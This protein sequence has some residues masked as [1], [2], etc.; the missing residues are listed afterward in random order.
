MSE[1]STGIFSSLFNFR[2]WNINNPKTNDNLKT[3]E[4]IVVEEKTANLETTNLE[5]VNLEAEHLKGAFL[6]LT[7]DYSDVEEFLLNGSDEGIDESL[8]EDRA[9][10][11]FYQD[12]LEFRTKLVKSI[13]ERYTETNSRFNILVD[14][15]SELVNDIESTML[16][17]KQRENRLLTPMEIKL[18]ALDQI[19]KRYGIPTNWTIGNLEEKASKDFRYRIALT[20]YNRIYYQL[21]EEQKKERH[22]ETDVSRFK[23][24][25]ISKVFRIQK[26]HILE[27]ITALE[28]SHS[29]HIRL[30]QRGTTE[31]L[32]LSEFAQ[33][34]ITLNS[35]I[36]RME[37][38]SHLQVSRTDDKYENSAFL[39]YGR[40]LQFK[41]FPEAKDFYQAPYY[42]P[43]HSSYSVNVTTVSGNQF[44]LSAKDLSRIVNAA[45]PRNTND[46]YTNEPFEKRFYIEA[47]KRNQ[48][49]SSII[50]FI[51]DTR[52]DSLLDL[53]DRALARKQ[54]FNTPSQTISRSVSDLIRYEMLDLSDTS[55]SKLKGTLWSGYRIHPNYWHLRDTVARKMSS[56]SF[57]NIVARPQIASKEAMQKHVKALSPDF[58]RLRNSTQEQNQRYSNARFRTGEKRTSVR[59]AAFAGLV[60][61][62]A[63]LPLAGLYGGNFIVNNYLNNIALQHA[64]GPPP[65]FNRSAEHKANTRELRAKPPIQLRNFKMDDEV[66]SY[67]VPRNN[68]SE[69]NDLERYTNNAIYG[70][71]DVIAGNTAVPSFYSLTQT[72]NLPES[73]ASGKITI[74]DATESAL[75]RRV[76][77]DKLDELDGSLNSFDLKVS[78]NIT[79]QTI[80]KRISIISP[81]GFD[82]RSIEITNSSGHVLVPSKDYDVYEIL[83]NGLFYARMNGNYRNLSY[84]VIYERDEKEPIGS[85]LLQLNKSFLLQEVKQLKAAGMT[86]LSTALTNLIAS[87]QKVSV[88]DIEA[89]FKFY[90]TY[91]YVPEVAMNTEVSEPYQYFTRFLHNG[92]LLYQCTGSN[93]LFVTFFN[94]YFE[95]TGQT[96]YIAHTK[97][98]LLA[99]VTP[100]GRIILHPSRGHRTSV[101][102][103]QSGDSRPV[104]NMDATPP[105]SSPSYFNEA[106]FQP[107]SKD[108]QEEVTGQQQKE[109]NQ[110]E[111]KNFGVLPR[112]IRIPK[113]TYTEVVS[114]KSDKSDKGADHD[115][116]EVYEDSL[117]SYNYQH[118]EPLI[119][120][121][122]RNN[123]QFKQLVQELFQELE[124]SVKDF[125]QHLFFRMINI[126]E[127]LVN[128]YENENDFRDPELFIEIL[129][130]IHPRVNHNNAREIVLKMID[131]FGIEETMQRLITT[132]QDTINQELTASQGWSESE[133]Y[134]QALFMN[135]ARLK[136]LI[137]QG[138]LENFL[139]SDWTYKP[140]LAMTCKQI[141]VFKVAKSNTNF[142]DKIK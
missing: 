36:G 28:D 75:V 6:D 119:N 124:T 72:Y 60:A 7:P 14:P 115:E 118:L 43:E 102:G 21:E 85:E 25:F 57:A 91:S 105:G 61:F 86:Q 141:L 17:K 117:Y 92:Q 10:R 121:L 97:S 107:R 135:D 64:T 128:H 47:A 62:W 134:N 41:D 2:F 136:R 5:A 129:Q 55:N 11:A 109:R 78:A 44:T 26:K 39:A 95:K 71:F 49:L 42:H 76:E 106:L 13:E 80:D 100:D 99:G 3:K 16:I 88:M 116:K 34:T 79:F 12:G 125:H 96:D 111:R 89:V 142:G 38:K 54:R 46:L 20:N 120:Q 132:A 98:G 87:K 35:T 51:L 63:S 59:A 23:R 8:F 1:E 112:R 81:E 90:S 4:T 133:L 94:Q 66:Y 73:L 137:V 138:Y 70:H 104:I 113:P 56:P 127:L 130:I 126:S 83:E 27:T 84:V 45:R 67:I 53:Y 18:L 110:E 29:I 58:K 30:I 69:T 48:N 93:H 24:W 50:S 19:K 31:T 15:E 122:R 74:N 139:K 32:T 103:L 9:L 140:D 65:N 22:P 40:N 131:D 108:F 77:L 52:D 82:V 123:S 37:E 33:A 68:D 114:D 101:I